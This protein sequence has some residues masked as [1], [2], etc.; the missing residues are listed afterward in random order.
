MNYK[1]SLFKLALAGLM[2]FFVTGLPLQP[3]SRAA[4]ITSNTFSQSNQAMTVDSDRQL[5]LRFEAN[6]GQTDNQVKFLARGS[7]YNLFLAP[8]EAVLALRKPAVLEG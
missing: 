6:Q 3:V 2:A 1:H 5:T 7:G 8:T 4:S